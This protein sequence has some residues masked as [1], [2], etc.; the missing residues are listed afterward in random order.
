M[1]ARALIPS[2]IGDTETL[3]ETTHGQQEWEENSEEEHLAC[4]PLARKN[5]LPS[6]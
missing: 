1:N 5:S 3:E 4:V 2:S 6:V